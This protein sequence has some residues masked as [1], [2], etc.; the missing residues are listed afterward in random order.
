MNRRIQVFACGVILAGSLAISGCTGGG[1]A[2][3]TPTPG[4]ETATA[5]ATPTPT[6]TF[7]PFVAET[8]SPEEIAYYNLKK[9]AEELVLAR[10]FEEALPVLDE[11]STIQPD[12]LD[13]IFLLLLTHGNLETE[14][15]VGS[16]AYEYAQKLIELKADAKEA[17]RARSYIAS[18]HSEPEEPKT[19]VGADTIAARRGF[20][21]EEGA[22]Y[23]LTTDTFLFTGAAQSLGREGKKRLWEMEVYPEGETEMLGIPKGQT[24]VVLAQDEYYYSKNAWRGPV[25]ENSKK[26]DS[27]M[28]QVGAFYVEITSD[29][30]FKGKRGWIVNQ[31][32]RWVTDEDGKDPW[33]VWIPNRLLVPYGS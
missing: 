17:E 20:K 10:S 27:S 6:S 29:G 30:E 25:P 32:D 2:D 23:E 24:M 3:A 16:P 26:W 9:K 14:P 11:A 12:D 1:G 7:T 8:A 15:V 33:G 18:A 4:G 19:R 28:Y 22:S 31:L 5:S 13:V 21:P